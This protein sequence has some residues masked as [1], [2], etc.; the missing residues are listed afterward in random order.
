MNGKCFEC[1]FFKDDQCRRASHSFSTLVDPICLQKIS[2]I[3]LRDIANTLE[4]M[5]YEDD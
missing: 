4:D 5:A 3:L 1:D 2:V